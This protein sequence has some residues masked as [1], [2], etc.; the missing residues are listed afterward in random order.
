MKRLSPKIDQE[1]LIKRQR[2][3]EIE[4]RLEV[5]RGQSGEAVTLKDVNE[6]LD[7]I[8]DMLSMMMDGRN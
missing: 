6:K 3:M 5:L 1:Q 8:L 7:L 2:Q 4:Q